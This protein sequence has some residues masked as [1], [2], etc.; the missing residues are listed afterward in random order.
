MLTYG[1]VAGAIVAAMIAISFS[2]TGLNVK[3]GELIG[4]STMILAF[5]TIFSAVKSYRDKHLGGKITFGKALKI[6]LGITVVASIIYV[7]A[8]VIISDTIA[9]D[10][11]LE[12]YQHSVDQLKQSNLSEA[13]IKAKIK[14]M[15]YFQELYK[16]PLVKIGITFLEIFP[17]GSIISF[18]AA[19]ILKRK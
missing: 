1:A 18:I 15:E 6:G 4:Y 7:I 5:S 17:V 14:E 8:W 10:F 9:K 19:F 3:Y 16:N 12:Y 13:E 11:M 2:I